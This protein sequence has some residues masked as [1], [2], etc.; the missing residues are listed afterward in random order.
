MAKNF[1][2]IS[3]EKIV[4]TIRKELTQLLKNTVVSWILEI[5]TI[6]DSSVARRKVIDYEADVFKKKDQSQ[7][8]PFFDVIFHF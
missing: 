2:V 1:F 5:W 8:R 6:N 7:L 4:K 3:V